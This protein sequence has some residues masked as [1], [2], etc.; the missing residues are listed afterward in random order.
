MYVSYDHHDNV[1]VISINNPPV[2]A[3]SHEVRT[4]ICDAVQ[5]F[6]S[7]S[8]TKVAIIYGMGRTF[9]AGADIREFGKPILEPSLNKVIDTIEDSEKPIVALLHG[10][11]LGGGFEL[12]LGCHFRVGCD[13]MKLGLPEVNLGLIPG[14]GGTQRLPRIIGFENAL[15]VVALGREINPQ[16]ALKIGLI[17]TLIESQGKLTDLSN[18]AA[19]ELYL[20]AG[21]KFAHEIIGKNTKI[22]RVSEL[23]AKEVDKEQSAAKLLEIEK[24]VNQ[25]RPGEIAP[26]FGIK[27]LKTAL[28]H[29]FSV[30]REKERELFVQLM[31]G[32][33]SKAMIHA[34]FAE[35][36]V[37]KVPELKSA[38]PESITT[39]GIV[40]GGTMGSGIAAACLLSGLKV[41]L[42][43]RNEESLHAAR[44][45]ITKILNESVMRNKLTEELKTKILNKKLT[46][47]IDFKILSDVEMVIEAGYEDM[48]V[49]TE[50]FSKL[51][52]TCRENCILATNTSYLNVDEIARATNR[53]EKVI[54]LHFFSPAYVMKLLEV[55]VGEKTSPE[56]VATGFQF[57]K[58]LNKIAVRSGVCEGFIGNRILT[59]YRKCTDN[60]VLDGANPYDIDK[61]LEEFGFRMGPYRVA[62]L[63]GLD[64]GWANRKRVENTRNPK[65]RY[66][67]F[68]DQIC[69]R[70]WFGRKSGIGFYIY[71]ENYPKGIPND[72]LAAIIA[73]ERA[74]LGIV[75]RQFSYEEIIDRCLAAI[76]NESANIVS[77]GI[78]L[79][80]LDI[81]VVFINGYGFPRW[82]GGPL[83]YADMIGL[84]KIAS[85]IK[86]YAKEDRNFWCLA[87]LLEKLLRDSRNFSS[88][89]ESVKST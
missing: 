19:R 11:V 60:M 40:G 32:E 20:A 73:D 59:A 27:A 26:H 12:A 74:E 50:I 5:H 82:R 7:D 28:N 85:N 36:Q 51:E 72:E 61:A 13:V 29:K 78:A 64:I 31:E 56:V 87:P 18:E 10:S 67:K 34:F 38:K 37:S 81:D 70:N 86:N 30:G 46:Y 44:T 9:S 16:R 54:G 3:L 8:N 71:E 43:E 77:E 49:K 21:T 33:Q 17:S 69:E 62:D 58:K 89:N 41:T 22:Q 65:E 4:G 57:A 14:A 83:F 63:A 53:A 23:A 47:S 52:Q 68:P 35:R 45:R 88:L 66:A 24:K 48:A 39:I 79:R 1:C 76:I 15:D 25:Q 6:N 84:E 42:V 75:T 2:N 55:V 80:P